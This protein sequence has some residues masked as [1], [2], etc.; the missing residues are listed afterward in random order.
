MSMMLSKCSL[1]LSIRVSQEGALWP[2]SESACSVLLTYSSH[3][4]IDSVF[5][6]IRRW[7]WHSPKCCRWLT[8]TVRDKKKQTNFHL[9][10]NNKYR[11][12]ILLFRLIEQKA[13]NGLLRNTVAKKSAFC[14]HFGFNVALTSS[15]IWRLFRV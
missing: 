4:D 7:F 1:I 11:C 3:N 10:L 2:G 8:E 5:Q 13:K 15:V 14:L 12:Y 9:F 6:F